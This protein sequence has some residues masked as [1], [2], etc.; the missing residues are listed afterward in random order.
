[1]G[2][3]IE[4]W[5]IKFSQRWNKEL[6]QNHET[7]FNLKDPQQD[8]FSQTSWAK[9]NIQLWQNSI[10]LNSIFRSHDPLN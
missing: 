8:L 7:D 2:H 5:Q 6:K 4:L 10:R 9:T 1:M 3:L